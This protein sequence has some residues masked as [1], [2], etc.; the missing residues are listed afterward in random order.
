MKTTKLI[1]ASALFA[2]L[3][4]FSF[5]GMGAQYWTQQSKNAA[6]QKTQAAASTETSKEAMNCATCACCSNAK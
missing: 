5:A 1:L 2:S 4:A 3:A 6:A